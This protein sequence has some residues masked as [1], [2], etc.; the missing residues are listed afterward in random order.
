MLSV[1]AYFVSKNFVDVLRAYESLPTHI[2]QLLQSLPSDSLA[3]RRELI[4][5]TRH[6][7]SSELRSH[8]LP[9]IEVLLNET[10]LL[11][12]HV[13][14]LRVLL[15]L[16]RYAWFFTCFVGSPLLSLVFLSPFVHSVHSLHTADAG[17]QGLDVHRHAAAVGCIHAGRLCAQC[18]RR[19]DLFAAVAGRASVPAQHEGTPAGLP[20]A[21][22]SPLVAV[23][24]M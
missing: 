16:E 9:H 7:L 22:M 18:A 6:F 21:R 3:V 10:T 5:A 24:K 19:A 4:I 2:M 17:R 13:M 14:S 11:G 20:H 1:L 15:F 8:F 23:V 12:I